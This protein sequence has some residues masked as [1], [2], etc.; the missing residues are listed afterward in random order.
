MNFANKFFK[1]TIFT[2]G[3][4]TNFGIA[5]EF[6]MDEF[7]S[8]EYEFNSPEFDSPE[9]TVKLIN[10]NTQDSKGD[11]TPET[12]VSDSKLQEAIDQRIVEEISVADSQQKGLT[13]PKSTIFETNNVEKIMRLAESFDSETVFVFDCD[14]V[15][16]EY[17][18]ANIGENLF[19]ELNKKRLESQFLGNI[20][21]TMFLEAKIKTVDNGMIKLINF[22]Q[23][24]LKSKALVLTQ[25]GT[26]KLGNIKSMVDWR[27]SVLEL[28]GYD[29]ASSWKCIPE[30]EFYELDKKSPRSIPT[31]TIPVFK[32]GIACACDVDKGEFLTKVL[33]YIKSEDKSYSPKKIFYVDDNIKQVES[34]ATAANKLN[35]DFIGVHYTASKNRTNQVL[36]T[37]V[38]YLMKQGAW[39]QDILA[40]AINAVNLCFKD[41]FPGQKVMGQ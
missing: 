6:D 21:S 36:Q 35:M 32:N 16:Q 38:Y 14:G 4:F 22:I 29:F 41:F 3:I 10:F 17:S 31:G 1:N 9:A 15:L 28:L 33:D 24:I 34:V 8:L 37:Q 11:D 23:W 26:G 12:S 30:K 2:L 18:D 13:A 19:K 25:C 5:A 7:I 39:V 27:I 20:I 40:C